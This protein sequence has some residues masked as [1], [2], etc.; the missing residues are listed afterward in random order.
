MTPARVL[1]VEDERII[2][3]TIRQMLEDRGYSVVG[4]AASAQS[5]IRQVKEFSPDIV[6]MDIH[7]EGK[8]DG[9]EAAKQIEAESDTPII[10]LTAYTESET[11][12]RA[13][14]CN[15]YS[16]LVKPVQAA[17]LHATL[18]IALSKYASDNQIKH[19]ERRLRLA[20]DVSSLGVWECDPATSRVETTTH[21]AT[22][23]GHDGAEA[24]HCISLFTAI[25]PGDQA[26]LNTF[27]DPSVSRAP[28]EFTFRR[29]QDDA[30]VRWVEAYASNYSE[31][32]SGSTKTIGTVRDV[33]AQRENETR[34]RQAAALF[35]SMA[36][37][38]VIANTGL[39][40]TAT[41]PAFERICGFSAADASG[42]HIRRF[43]SPVP[44]T[45]SRWQGEA[46]CLRSDNERLAVWLTV[47]PIFEKG[48][49]S[50]V[51]LIFSDI[52]PLRRAEANLD[53]LANH[54][55][56]TSL[57]NRLL[58]NRR[59]EVLT[60]EGTPFSVFYLD[61]DHFKLINDSR[62]H[63]VGDLVLQAIAGRIAAFLGPNCIGARHGGD[64]F[65]I[66][67]PR[68]KSKAEAGYFA[69][70]LLKAV[71]AP[72]PIGNESL[73]VTASVGISVFPEDGTGLAQLILA[74]DTAMYTAKRDGSNSYRHYHAG[75]AEP[76]AERYQIEQDIRHAFAAGQ[77]SVQYQPI[78]SLSDDTIAGAEALVR[79]RHPRHGMIGPDQFIPIAEEAGLI[80]QLGEVVL[81]IACGD[82]MLWI[83][84]G[85]RPPRLSINVSARQITRGNFPALL[86][87][88]LRE[89]PL[90]P[91]CIEIEIT[92]SS[93]QGTARS[94][95]FIREIKEIGASVAIDDFG[96]GYS[97]LA[98]LRDL[99]VDRIKLDRSFIPIGPPRANDLDLLRAIAGIAHSMNLKL[100]AEGIETADQL[101]L[102]RSV[103]CDEAQGYWLSRPMS[104]AEAA[105]FIRPVESGS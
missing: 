33:T 92:E 12:R 90:P 61:L 58:F 3:L 89:F 66:L 68:F 77:I 5:A 38:V 96:T 22:I 76:K 79:W 101:E 17:E 88:V 15:A 67:S 69:E 86:R 30:S 21:V 37:A 1:V 48:A 2:A 64:E 55:P 4:T 49:V 93:F 53:F 63:Y 18:Q 42:M 27:L 102:V 26:A 98:A 43:L 8:V 56:L 50:A 100:T 73:I 60:A 32:P 91:S 20:L 87:D 11:I 95:S 97:S 35:E 13:S 41:N 80:E 16:Y 74:A 23:L 44:A 78:V 47:A 6:L 46:T 9:I 14:E 83:E 70:V 99:P 75:L 40:V 72:V 45:S 82:W 104:F 31:R 24:N 19:S 54:D 57:P 34:L 81:R 39:L 65:A 85:S 59:M 7:L 51:A 84:R 62:G 10:F 36:D 29:I 94:Q 25:H 103:G 52:S 28:R 105:A 71:S